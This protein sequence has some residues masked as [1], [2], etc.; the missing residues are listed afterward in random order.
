MT[1]I[2]DT[3][4]IPFAERGEVVR[5]VIAQTMVQVDMKFARE[6]VQGANAY[7]VIANIG[8]MR[9]ISG[10]SNATDLWR[11]PRFARDSLEP[12]VVLVLQRSRSS[13][14]MSQ[15]G[16]ESF[17][18]RGQLAFADST[19]PYLLKDPNGI[20]Q[21]NFAIKTASLGIPVDM[22]KRLRAVPLCPGHPIALLAA[23]YLGHLAATP[24]SSGRRD[25]DVDVLDRPTIELVRALMATHLEVSGLMK[26]SLENVLL[27]RLLEY[28]RR[29][30]HDPHL[31]AAQIAAEHHISVRH[32]YSVLS[33]GDVCLGDWIRTRRL[34]A[35]HDN[36]RRLEYQNQTIASIARRSG[37]ADASTFGRLFRG[38]YGMSPNE[39]RRCG[40]TP[41]AQPGRRRSYPDGPNGP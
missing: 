14:H 27:M 35:C 22:I 12:T 11:T 32:L 28:A 2:L 3:S 41:T 26:E 18:P 19:E 39:W 13:L 7:G 8:G 16:R 38:A 20:E 21:D 10:H 25:T 30:L 33:K 23:N 31:N 15:S 40:S 6:Q 5:N 1:Q 34:E 37:F 24:G 4:L 17:L 29:N 36:L 9:I